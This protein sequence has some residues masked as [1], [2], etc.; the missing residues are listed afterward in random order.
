MFCFRDKTLRFMTKHMGRF[1][2]ELARRI[3][4]ASKRKVFFYKVYGNYLVFALLFVKGVYFINVV[5]QLFLLNHF[6]GTKYNL[7]GLEVLQR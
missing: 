4:L 7:Y 6:L 1:L 2:A 3:M 5:G